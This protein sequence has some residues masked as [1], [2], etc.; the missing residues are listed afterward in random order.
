MTHRFKCRC[1]CFQAIVL[2]GYT[3]RGI[4]CCCSDCRA[5]AKY[6]DESILIDGGGIHLIEIPQNRFNILKGKNRVRAL[7]FS[8]GGLIRW[9]CDC[10]YTPIGN[11]RDNSIFS[12]LSLINFFPETGFIEKDFR[13]FTSII[14]RKSVNQEMKLREQDSFVNWLGKM[15]R[16]LVY[17]IS[18]KDRV[19]PFF[20][21]DG[22]PISEPLIVSSELLYLLKNT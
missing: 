1:G 14:G 5:F 18:G 4:I 10:C 22:K 6:C 2:G 20:Y 8:D 12:M 7:R 15:A 19:S 3:S 13:F 21:A 9:F 16:M 17:V 11:T